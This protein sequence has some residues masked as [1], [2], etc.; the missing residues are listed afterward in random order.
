MLKL[1]LF[2]VVILLMDGAL[3]L[4]FGM[5]QIASEYA[6]LGTAMTVVMLLLGNVTFFM[7]D[8]VLGKRMVRKK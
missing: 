8:M 4:L 3:I 2:N 5:D 1:I 6:Q 7:L